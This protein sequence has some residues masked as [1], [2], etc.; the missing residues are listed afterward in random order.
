MI[1]LEPLFH[2]DSLCIAIRGK[3]SQ[4]VSNLI[5]KFPGILY[6]Q[7]HRCFYVLYSAEALSDLKSTLTPHVECAAWGWDLNNSSGF[8]ERYASILVTVPPEY[9]E[10]LIKMRY[11]QATLENYLAQF[12]RFLVFIF[13]ATVEDITDETIHRYSLFLVRERKVSGS[14][15][16]QAINSIK[17]YLEYVKKGERKTYYIER[18]RKEQKLP[19]VLSESEIEKL[20]H[21]TSNIK[22]RCILLLLYSSGLRISELLNLRQSDIDPDRKLIHVKGGKGKKDRVTVLSGSVFEYLSHYLTKHNP[23]QWVFEG[24]DGNRYSERSVNRI[25]KRSAERAAIWKRV[26]A[27]TL[28]HSFATHLLEHGTDLRYI[29]ALLGHESSRTTKRY[30]HVTTRGLGQLVSPLDNLNKNIIFGD[31]K[32]I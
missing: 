31:N 9:E 12:K 32:E 10:L 5:R 28:R 4:V 20:L 21:H 27:H 8:R 11:I 17:F 2:C 15:Q 6:S 18:P 16:N 7:T 25:I 30:A 22:H 26:S 3:Y 23:A 14:T 13:P 29:Q 1:T 19:V 24:R